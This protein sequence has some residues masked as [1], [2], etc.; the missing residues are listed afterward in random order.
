MSV[1]FY[2]GFVVVGSTNA[3]SIVFQPEVNGVFYRMF[4]EWKV[5]LR[6]VTLALRALQ[7]WMI[8]IAV[9][10]VALLPDLAWK[11]IRKTFWPNPTE[12]ILLNEFR[13]KG[14]VRPSSLSMH[15]STNNGL[16]QTGEN[17]PSLDRRR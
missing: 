9:P 4:S 3:F 7:F 8:I 16:V 15:D 5:S 11:L 10:L 14:K 12:V 2:W 6:G 1:C 13:K 17:E